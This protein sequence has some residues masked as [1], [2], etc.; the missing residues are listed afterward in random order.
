MAAR[1]VGMTHRPSS[2][3][4]IDERSIP[5]RLA[6]SMAPRG[7]GKIWSARAR[8][9][10]GL[11]VSRSASARALSGL[12][13]RSG[14]RRLGLGMPRAGQE[15]CP[16]FPWR[17]VRARRAREGRRDQYQG[18][19][20]PGFRL[21]TAGGSRT[22]QVNRQQF[23]AS[24]TFQW[25]SF[26]GE[27]GAFYVLDTFLSRGPALRC[28]SELGRRE[29]RGCVYARRGER[30]TVTMGGTPTIGQLA[31]DDAFRLLPHNGVFTCCLHTSG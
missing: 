25:R 1:T 3:V 7:G 28:P 23:R 9:R 10:C 26:G 8:N 31:S 18:V 30:Q 29:T 12:V 27:R 15:G 19:E 21:R 2:A 22:E 14:M 24:A 5:R 20:I 16:S 11:R 17:S 4:R 13:R 6:G